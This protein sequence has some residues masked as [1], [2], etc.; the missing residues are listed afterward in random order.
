MPEHGP[1]NGLLRLRS[2][3]TELGLK[4]MLLNGILALG[5]LLLSALLLFLLVGQQLH[6]FHVLI[7]G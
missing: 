4:L 7:R 2:L 5:Q 1:L 3:D 6:H